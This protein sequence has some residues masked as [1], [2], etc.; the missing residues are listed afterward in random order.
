MKTTI[1]KVLGKPSDYWI[2]KKCNGLNWY[3]NEICSEENQGSECNGK[4]PK[5][6]DKR[7]LKVLKWAEDE[8]EFYRELCDCDA[9]CSDEEEC[10]FDEDD[11][12]NIEIKC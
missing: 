1:A 11:C 8:I 12:D 6:T 10:E 3:E 9:C 5:L 2:C 4:Q 7:D